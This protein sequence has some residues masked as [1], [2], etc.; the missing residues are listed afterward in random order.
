MQTNIT[1]LGLSFLFAINITNSLSNS[2]FDSNDLMPSKLANYQ[3]LNSE[4]LPLSSNY[5]V[6]KILNEKEKI[7]V[8]FSNKL[9][10][11]MTDI[12]SEFVELVNNN[13][14]QI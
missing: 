11:N 5:T 12:D 8:D 14:W 1:S 2:S 13:F 9:L 10:T 6:N 3:A 4:Y 7:I